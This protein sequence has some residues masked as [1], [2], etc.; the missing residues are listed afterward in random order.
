MKITPLDINN[1]KFRTKFRGFDVRDVD[2]FLQAVAEELETCFESFLRF[3]IELL[4]TW[5]K[6][7]P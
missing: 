7:E 2:D 1:Q 6:R 4:D 3:N 5:N